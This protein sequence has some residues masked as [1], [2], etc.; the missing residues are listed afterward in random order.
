MKI[1]SGGHGMTVG[2]DVKDRL[3]VWVGTSRDQPTGRDWFVTDVRVKDVAVAL[4]KVYAILKDG[5][6]MSTEGNT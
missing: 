4:H 6:V 3:V 2:V 1:A 5:S